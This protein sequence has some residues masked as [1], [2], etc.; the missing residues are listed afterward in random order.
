MLK[1]LLKG[2]LTEEQREAG[3]YLE[4]DE[5][6]LY[7]FDREGKRH[8]VFSSKTATPEVLQKEAN[9]IIKGG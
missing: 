8:G 3:I 7:L 1:E 4:E 5:D 6:F 2:V 9:A